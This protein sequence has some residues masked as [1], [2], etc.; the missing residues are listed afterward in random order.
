MFARLTTTT[1]TTIGGLL[2]RLKSDCRG[3][4]LM[5]FGFAVIP[6]TFAAGFGV[7]YGRAMRLETHLNAAAD[8]AALA[9]V[10]PTMMFESDAAAKQAAV[11]MFETQAEQMGGYR[12]LDVEPKVE[13]VTTGSGSTLGFLRKVTISYTAESIN[14]FGGILGADTLTISGSAVASA[15]QPP[16]VDFYLAM[17]NSPSMLL[18]ATSDGIAKVIAATKNS[19]NANGC[20]YAC[21]AQ[22][23]HKDS[24][25]IRDTQ[26]RDVLLSTSYYTA[27]SPKNSWW[28]RWDARGEQLFDSN[29]NPMNSTVTVTADPVTQI[30]RRSYRC[31]WWSTCY[32][33]ET[34]T[35]TETT[36]TGV[37]YTLVDSS[38]GPVT[39]NRAVTTITDKHVEVSETR[40]NTSSSYDTKGSPVTQPSTVYD[41]GYWADGFWLTHN[42]GKIFGSPERLQLR[43]DAMVAAATQ[44]IPFAANQ[45][46]DYR[47]T[48]QMQLFSFD[49]T[50]PGQST[51]VRQLTGLTD[52]GIYNQGF[53]VESVF[54]ADDYWYQNGMP[55]KNLD[56]GDR[57][58]EMLN[59]LNFMN[60]HIPNAGNGAPGQTPQKIMFLI[61]DGMLDQP[62]GSRVMGPM[63]SAANKELAKCSA[64]KARGIKIAIL[65]TQYLPE[66]L[67]GD[68]WSQSN[69][70]PWLPA[71]PSPYPVGNAGS[72][73]QIL[74][75]LQKCASPG[76]N[77][78]PLVQTVTSDDNIATALRTLFSTTL[79]TARLIK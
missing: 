36:T 27:G 12:I 62:D 74:A 10:S 67:V 30:V 33:N 23:P 46:D 48:Y 76:N 6:L 8:A 5:I 38:S 55:T 47:V 79:Q 29:G 77:G 28:Y 66:S 52:V 17:D 7:D 44:L 60:S 1:T 22:M 49:W 37:R 70:A 14:S 21:H 42:Y 13:K 57:T 25:W 58:T 26:G 18:P 71:P 4:V 64:L 24:I 3:N 11:N 2:R 63:R 78:A 61:T 51:P 9:A 54:P 75:A 65:Y 69:V 35:T 16:N 41:Y 45:A 20:A 43:K 73:D 40:Y 68:S 32:Y 72:S 31:G 15:A 56:V 53:S 19:H 34:T 50:R 59:M 39:I